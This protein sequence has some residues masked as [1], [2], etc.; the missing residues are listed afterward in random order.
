VMASCKHFYH[1][2]CISKV[3]DTHNSCV[4]CKATFHP[5][6]WNS[7]GFYPLQIDLQD[8]VGKIC[9]V[10]SMEELSDTLKDNFGFPIL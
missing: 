7:F 3:V 5:T 10:K 9:L 4:A 6:W 1:P 2:F 8:D